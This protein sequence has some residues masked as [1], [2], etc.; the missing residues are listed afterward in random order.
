MKYHIKQFK[1]V[2][3]PKP[4]K[5]LKAHRPVHNAPVPFFVTSS[6]ERERIYLDALFEIASL[7]E[8]ELPSR[9]GIVRKYLTKISCA[10]KRRLALRLSAKKQDRTAFFAGSLCAGLC[11]T[12]FSAILVV[13]GLFGRFMLP[14]R[15]V[16]VPSVIGKYYTELEELGK[17]D[18]KF[19]VG[20]VS[21]DTVPAG[22]VISQQPQ[23]SVTRK[24]FRKDKYYIVSVNVS[25][26]K[27][28]YVVEDLAGLSQRA[29]L[30]KL[31]NN[32]IAVDLVEKYSDT[33]PKGSVIS[34]LPEENERLYSGQSLTL[35]VS[36][37]KEI[38]TV[39]VP[40]LYALSEAQATRALEMR[41][42][43]LGKILYTTS[44]VDAGKV[45]SQQYAAFSN[46]PDGTTVDI[47]VSIGS[48][49]E[50][51]VVPNLY[52]LTVDE[53]EKA[54]GAVGLVIGNIYSVT[55]GAPKGT[56]I[57]QAPVANTPIT[58]TVISVDIYVS[59]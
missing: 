50:Q 5:V 57:S 23:P 31:K 46:V 47:T 17:N 54:L 25:S 29:A 53:A 55:S 6:T 36:L 44:S 34:T 15:E 33:V 4:N 27:S 38:P 32:G 26:G 56:V 19:I 51:K 39:R 35:Y 7:P 59:S 41:G 22:T 9:K 21:S 28:F 37:G 58:S 45:I 2:N 12:V 52:G 11:V 3:K 13:I 30:L 43:K 24:L 18:F 1:F 16:T 48:A 8:A 20:Y 42:L 14:F 49:Y 40:D 10:L